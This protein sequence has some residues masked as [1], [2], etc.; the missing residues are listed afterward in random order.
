[1]K[2][3]VLMGIA[4]KNLDSTNNI[5]RIQWESQFFFYT[6]VDRL[7]FHAGLSDYPVVDGAVGS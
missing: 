2:H 1:M 7:D 3:R 6:Y 4:T 5:I